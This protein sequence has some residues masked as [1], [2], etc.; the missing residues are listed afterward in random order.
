MTYTPHSPQTENVITLRGYYSTLKRDKSHKKRVSW[1]DD[2]REQYLSR[3]H[4]AVIE[5]IGVSPRQGQAHRSATNTSQ[6]YI[7]TKPDVFS[8]IKTGM[9][10]KKSSSEIYKEMLLSNADDAPRDKHQIRNVT[11]NEKKKSTNSAIGNVADEII[12][13]LSMVNKDDFV[14]EVV[15]KNGKNKQPS[16][17]CYTKQQMQDMQQFLKTD[18]DRIF[19]Y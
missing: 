7:R 14:Q 18:N 16:I 15:Y 8:G 2:M 4:I 11:Y 5:Y 6:E 9:A 12:E 19:R 17:M 1:F 10:Q 3:S 13:V